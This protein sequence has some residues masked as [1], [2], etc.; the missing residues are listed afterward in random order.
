MQW[1]GRIYGF[2]P[3]EMI[4]TSESSS[5]AVAERDIL[6]QGFGGAVGKKTWFFFGSRIF[7]QCKE[8]ETF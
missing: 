5:L 8:Q 7:K 4:M 1:I 3:L 2:L 6:S